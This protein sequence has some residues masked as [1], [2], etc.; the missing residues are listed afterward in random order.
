MVADGPVGADIGAAE[1]VNRLLR[2]ADDEQLAG[3]GAGLR[4]AIGAVVRGR[5]QE[6]D[7]R[8]NG[9]GVLELVDE[10]PGESALQVAADLVI[11]TQ[12]IARAGQQV[13][14]IERAL[15]PLERLI[16]SRR[17][18]QHL[19]QQG[20]QVAVRVGAELQERRIE[21]VARGKDVG[22]HEGSIFRAVAFPGLRE[23]LIAREID[24]SRFPRI[25]IPLSERLLEL[26]L[27]ALAANPIEGLEQV[28]L[29]GPAELIA[30]RTWSD[31]I[32]RSTSPSRSNARRIQGWVK[33]RSDG[34]RPAG[35][36][37][38]LDRATVLETAE[39]RTA[40]P[41]QGTPHARRRIFQHV[42]QPGAER[43]RIQ[44]L[45]LWLGQDR[46][47]RVNAGFDRPLPSSSAQKP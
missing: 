40:R 8:L 5:Q 33:S 22:S 44:P 2:I 34:E 16:L 17:L 24:Q 26:N 1:P 3:F 28:V 43:T 6:Q 45:G 12:Q 35:A 38:P 41:A 46:E 23:A 13:C 10:D 11:G 18:L 4:P 36:A 30:A 7:F 42:L 32:R 37:Q 31:A 29:V 14:E 15:P 25:E 19:L 21:R 20:R 39:C 47:K 9:I 27:L